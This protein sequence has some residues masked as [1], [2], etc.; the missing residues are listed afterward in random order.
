MSEKTQKKMHDA[1]TVL[2]QGMPGFPK[3]LEDTNHYRKIVSQFLECDVEEV[4]FTYNTS[5]GLSLVMQGLEW[6]EGDEIIAFDYDFPANVMP[7][8]Q[9]QKQGVKVHLVPC[10]NYKYNLDVY[11]KLLNKKTKLVVVS[12]VN[13]ITGEV[14]DVNRICEKAHEVSALVSV[15]AIQGLGAVPF[16]LKETPAD[17]LS[18]GG[19]KWLRGPMGSGVFFCRKK[20]LDLLKNVS[21]GWLGYEN[22]LDF[23][24][25]GEGHFSYELKPKKTAERF[26]TGV[27][28][29]MNHVGLGSAMEELL[30][31]GKIK[32]HQKIQKLKTLLRSELEKLDVQIIT[33]REGQQSG[34]LSFRI[35]NQDGLKVFESLSTKGFSLAFPDGKIRVSPHFSNTEA[36][37]L[38]FV[39]VLKVLL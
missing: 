20:N 3:V 34:I 29:Y 21:L 26:E 11:E 23:L 8:Q 16:S 13:F 9:L 17:F 38:E 7:W 4:A 22:V 31:V 2:A 24:M 18:S 25:K 28:N 5:S 15:D 36:E 32:I 30:E 37:I 6:N 10:E 39:E 14:L 33:P 27:P 12:F 19:H 1:I 35:Q